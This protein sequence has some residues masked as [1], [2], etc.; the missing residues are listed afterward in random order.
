MV[1]V[2]GWS[3]EDAERAISSAATL[4]Y[5]L[6]EIPLFDPATADLRH[7]RDLLKSTASRPA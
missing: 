4:G 6:I 5:D 7:T 1:W 3:R 2:G